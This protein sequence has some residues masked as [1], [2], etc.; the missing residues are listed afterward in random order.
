MKNA[1]TTE[2]RDNIAYLTFDLPEA[3]VN[4]LNPAVM[5]ELAA[6]LEKMAAESA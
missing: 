3:R 6:L 5:E 1:F 2:T 4:I